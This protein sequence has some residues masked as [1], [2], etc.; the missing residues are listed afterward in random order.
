MQPWNYWTNDSEYDS[1]RTCYKPPIAPRNDIYTQLVAVLLTT[2]D[3]V[4]VAGNLLVLL[5]FAVDRRLRTPTHYFIGSLAAADLALG[6]FVLPVA[7]AFET[8]GAWTFGILLCQLWLAVDVWLCTASIYGLIMVGLDR[9]VAVTRPL[10]Y[11]SFM[12]RTRASLMI[13]MAWSISLVICL[14]TFVVS[15]FRASKAVEST[16]QC[17]Q[18][19]HGPV[20]IVYSAVGSFYL[21]MA[22]IGYVYVRIYRTIRQIK[23]Q[24]VS[25]VVNI[26]FVNSGGSEI[27]SDQNG[28]NASKTTFSSRISSCKVLRRKNGARLSIS[29]SVPTRMTMRVHKGG[30]RE[31][32]TTPLLNR[33]QSERL[34]PPLQSLGGH[35]R[36]VST[37]GYLNPHFGSAIGHKRQ[38]CANGS[39][40]SPTPSSPSLSQ[41]TLVFDSNNPGLESPRATSTTSF[42]GFLAVPNHLTSM[43]YQR[44][45]AF[46]RYHQ[47]LTSELG[48]LRTVGIVTGCFVACWIGFCIVYSIHAWPKCRYSP[49]GGGSACVPDWVISLM[50][51]FG[52]ANS[53]INPI[54]YTAS[55]ENFR[56]AFR[57]LVRCEAISRKSST[58]TP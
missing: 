51:W 56:R 33:K 39:M 32:Q 45:D 25:G 58:N 13:A 4:V 15:S 7:I 57:T 29:R 30:Y 31:D 11:K 28:G 26:D 3:V 27:G 46:H 19:V 18:M 10:A 14:P 44:M 34:M 40:L 16:C 12:T 36:S 42:M 52:Y 53:A 17:T 49:E 41:S 35:R 9:Y 21:P 2:L 50:V 1:N 37:S 55:N 54:I 47:K 5:A 20:Y 24:G 8:A 22:I 23:L 43:W 6:V 48:A 38:A